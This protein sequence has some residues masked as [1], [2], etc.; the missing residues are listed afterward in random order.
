MVPFFLFRKEKQISLRAFRNLYV[1][2]VWFDYR[3]NEK[4]YHPV[5]F[6]FFSPHLLCFASFSVR[7]QDCTNTRQCSA[8]EGECNV[9]VQVH[10]ASRVTVSIVNEVSP[11][12]RH[13]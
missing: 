2:C 9:C 6:S 1:V 11:R 12:S 10:S 8:I 5:Q 4:Q 3:L 7:N 13:E